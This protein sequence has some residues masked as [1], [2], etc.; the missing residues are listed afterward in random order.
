MFRQKLQ[1]M[2]LS[3]GELFTIFWFPFISE[4]CSFPHSPLMSIKN[5]QCLSQ[6]FH[7]ELHSKDTHKHIKQVHFSPMRALA[8][9]KYIKLFALK[10]KRKTNI[11]T[12]SVI[13]YKKWEKSRYNNKDSLDC[14]NDILGFHNSLHLALF[15]FENEK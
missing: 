1:I 8:S 6:N 10:E 12:S 3:T 7:Q 9:G 11:S 13:L 4:R 2:P 5:E 14:K 15:D